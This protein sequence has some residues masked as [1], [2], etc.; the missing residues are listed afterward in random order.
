LVVVPGLS[1]DGGRSSVF[2]TSPRDAG[3]WVRH[4]H[5]L[6]FPLRG[7]AAGL[8]R[9]EGVDRDAVKDFLAAE[10]LRRLMGERRVA[11]GAGTRA[12]YALVCSG[13][14]WGRDRATRRGAAPFLE[15]VGGACEAGGG[16][17]AVSA[18]PAE[19]GEENPQTFG[20]EPVDWP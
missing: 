13:H 10:K 11:Y 20:E 17:V 6:P 5:Q 8:P 1:G 12:S 15:E 16:R 19:E 7:D 4:A 9:P 18:A 14:R 2:P 3:S